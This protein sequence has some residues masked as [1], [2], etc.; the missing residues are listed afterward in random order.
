M[1]CYD[2]SINHCVCVWQVLQIRS[3]R[4]TTHPNTQTVTTK[5]PSTKRM[6]SSAKPVCVCVVYFNLTLF[7]F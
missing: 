2:L 6:R 5:A 3:R 4:K 7:P 1:F